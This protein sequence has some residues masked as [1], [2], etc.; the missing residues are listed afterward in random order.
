MNIQKFNIEIHQL[1][2]GLLL[3]SGFPEL[4]NSSIF[5]QSF[6]P[7]LKFQLYAFSLIIREFFILLI[8]FK[9]IFILIRNIS[10]ARISYRLLVG[11]LPIISL[12]LFFL[13]VS[14]TSNFDIVTF[15]IGIRFYILFSLPLLVLDRSTLL[16]F[17]KNITINDYIFYFY[18]VLSILSLVIGYGD[19]NP[20]DFGYA[21]TGN[22][23]LG[24]R[25]MFNTANPI[26]AAQQFGMFLIY[27]NFRLLIEKRNFEKTKFLIISLLLLYL[28]LFTGGRAG[29]VVAFAAFISTIIIYYFPKI[30]YIFLTQKKI[31]NNFFI[32][33]T[34]F[35]FCICLFLLSSNP[36]ISG[37]KQTRNI[38]VRKGL[39]S[40]VY[41]NRIAIL[42]KYFKDNK[43]Q[44]II[45]GMPGGGT[46]TACNKIIIGENCATTDSLP[47]TSII[48]FGIFGILMY[49]VILFVVSNISYSPLMTIAFLVFSLS[50][51]FPE[52]ILPWTQFV[53]LLFHSN[54]IVK[55]H[56]V[57]NSKR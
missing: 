15:I 2:F 46:N 4:I 39:I 41:G 32:I 14:N 50:Q 26:I 36:L 13:Y 19:F 1:L 23:F 51:I 5:F 21:A 35:L 30:K 27:T 48:S 9:I 28:T 33:T 49:I 3:S 6:D 29:L 43:V 17:K 37:R 38:I 57:K 54:Q 11:F 45:F 7:N 34:L 8:G 52:L 18:L 12:V 16:N 22:T 40:G 44:D 56:K 47:T 42:S 31:K 55:M 25:Y 20:R 53:L 10:S 24:K